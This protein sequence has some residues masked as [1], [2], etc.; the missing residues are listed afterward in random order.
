LTDGFVDWIVHVGD[1][2]KGSD[3]NSAYCDDT[4]FSSQYNLFTAVEPEL[5]FL[6]LAG[7]NEF[8]REC[9]GWTPPVDDSDPVQSLW[10]SYFTINTFAG[11]DKTSPV[12]GTPVFRR[13]EG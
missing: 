8:S 13:Q 6:L 2:K 9:N 10:R 11:L 5:D 1:I 4:L 12:W 3:V 7:D